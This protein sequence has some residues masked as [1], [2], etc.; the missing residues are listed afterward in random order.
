MADPAAA[1]AAI[2]PTSMRHIVPQFDRIRKEGRMSVEEMREKMAALSPDSTLPAVMQY[3]YSKSVSAVTSSMS[4]GL[5]L[6]NG[7]NSTVMLPVEPY[8]ES[9]ELTDPA[10]IDTAFD[11]AEPAAA[12]AAAP[13]A[14]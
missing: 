2:D 3:R 6:S 7:A 8:R 9:Q 10:L 4:K 14:Q 12:P 1:P 11:K 13:A 5:R